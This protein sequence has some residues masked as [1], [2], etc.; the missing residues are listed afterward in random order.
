MDDLYFFFIN[1]ETVLNKKGLL[2]GFISCENFIYKLKQ[3]FNKEIKNDDVKCKKKLDF[4]YYRT[5]CLE[6]N[7]VSSINSR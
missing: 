2:K 3:T 4:M 1:L 7:R 6:L 5:Y